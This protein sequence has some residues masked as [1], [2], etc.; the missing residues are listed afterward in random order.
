MTAGEKRWL[1]EHGA[2]PDRVHV[3]P[4]GSI[5]HPAYDA[6][7]FRAAYHL[8]Q[9]PVV[10]FLA[11]KLPYKGYR[12]VV[13][14]APLVWQEMPHVYFLFVGPRTP[15]SERFF[16][17]VDDPRIIELPAIADPFEKTSLLAACDVLCVPSTKESLGAIHLEAWSLKKPVIAA[18]IEVMREIVTDGQD[19]L[20]VAQ[21]AAAIANAILRLLRDGPLRARMGEAGCRKVQQRYR[22][23]RCVEQMENLYSSLTTKASG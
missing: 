6:Q 17:Q 4:I 15:E 22:W 12:Q 11:Q 19:G 7:R 20:L 23:E 21:D 2:S 8:G 18:D 13:E 9:A 5:L 10:L 14:A 3:I 1:I 16:A